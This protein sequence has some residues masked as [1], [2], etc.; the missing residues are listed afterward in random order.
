LFNIIGT[1]IFLPFIGVLKD[2]IPAISGD[3]V[4]RQIANLHTFFNITNTLIMVWF[5]PLL[6]KI[7]MKLVPGED[8]EEDA[9][10]LEYLDRRLLETPSVAVGQL[11]KEI[12]RMGKVASDNLTT[13]YESFVKQDEKLIQEVSVKEELVN[14]LER[15]I[16][17][18]MVALSNT[19]LSEQQSEI[20]TSLFHVVNDVERISDHAD[21]LSELAQYR[22][23][24][25]I[26]FSEQAITELNYMYELAK[27]AVDNSISA[28]GNFDENLAKQAIKTEDEIDKLEKQLRT[29]HIERLN[30]GICYPASGAIFLDVIT[31]LE[32]VGDHSTNIA[33]MVIS[34]K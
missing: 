23:N 12:V 11:V 6:I 3:S 32:R 9:V 25:K 5:I 20:I 4:P 13:S 34:T 10:S 30:K 18:Y 31:N 14:Y 24:S 33:E 27:S 29:D 17:S 8:K 28:L 26:P 19:H 1:V 2:F 15:E 16:T 7:V 22:I 21:N